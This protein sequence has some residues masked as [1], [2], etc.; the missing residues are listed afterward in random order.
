MI[1]VEVCPGCKQPGKV[2][3]D[4][5]WHKETMGKC[6]VTNWYTKTQFQALQQRLAEA[7]KAQ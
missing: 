7:K 6:P 1:E 2:V 3:G 4:L 5:T